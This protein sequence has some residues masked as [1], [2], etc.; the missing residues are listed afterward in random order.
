[1]NANPLIKQAFV[2]PLGAMVVAMLAGVFLPGYSSI[3]QHLSEMTVL[4]SPAATITRVAS[5]VTGVSLL[6]FGLG[7]VLSAGS[8]FALTALACALGGA[9]MTSNGIFVMGHP[10]HG[11]GEPRHRDLGGNGIGGHGGAREV[12]GG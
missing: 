4:D 3:S 5:V 11:L 1:M 8:R 10:L 9:A 12:P 7:L 2:A 6:L